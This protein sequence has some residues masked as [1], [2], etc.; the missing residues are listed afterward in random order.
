MSAI[1]LPMIEPIDKPQQ[2]LVTDHSLS[3]IKLAGELL[4]RRF[5][6]V[7][8]DFDLMG[9]S[10]GMF[11]LERRHCRIR[12]NP[13]LFAKYFEENLQG[14]VPHEVAHYIVHC[15]YGLHRVRPHGEE[16]RAI[17]QAFDA[18]ASVTGDYDL[19]GIPQRRQRRFDYR[20]DCREH[21]LSTRRHNLIER[22]KGR[23]QCRLCSAELAYA[24]DQR[25]LQA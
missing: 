14:T 6:P 18:D 22:G 16:W 21:Q 4:G 24:G 13:W 8:I 20:C 23:Y 1:I 17:M 5:D 11:K 25:E 9:S 3:Y 12:Y 7:A 19:S 10:A 2:Q 15:L